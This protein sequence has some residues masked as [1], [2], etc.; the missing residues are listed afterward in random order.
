MPLTKSLILTSELVAFLNIISAASFSEPTILTSIL[1]HNDQI[2]QLVNVNIIK[3]M[4]L[5]IRNKEF[6]YSKN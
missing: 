4:T 3:I 6:F 1:R 2:F 5:V